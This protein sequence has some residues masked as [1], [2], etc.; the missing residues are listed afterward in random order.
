MLY[1]FRN[2]KKRYFVQSQYSLVVMYA[3]LCSNPSLS[4]ELCNISYSPP[5]SA[6]VSQL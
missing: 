4:L 5:S 3:G 2:L 1:L 6:Q